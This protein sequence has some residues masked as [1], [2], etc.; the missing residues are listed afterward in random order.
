MK[1]LN[2]IF[3]N[4]KL[5]KQHI[6]TLKKQVKKINDIKLNNFK[7]LGEK[8]VKKNIFLNKNS[9]LVKYIIDIRFSKSN[10]LLHIMNFKGDLIFFSS[11]GLLN[12]KGKQ[13]K[14]RFLVFKE[15][16]KILITKFRFIKNQP[17]ALHL[18]NVQSSKFWIIKTL[19]KK[20]FIK[21]IKNYNSFPHNGCRKRKM[22]RKKF[23]K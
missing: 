1:K 11:A 14:A 17:I 22:K 20:F 18:K 7:L 23:K 12:Y 10:T 4:I 9:L 13:K 8:I 19:K 5:K 16:Y 15:F 3:K 21:V 2:N 6:V